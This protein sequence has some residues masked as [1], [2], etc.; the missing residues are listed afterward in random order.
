MP[1]FV[2]L[3][4]D[5]DRWVHADFRSKYFN[6]GSRANDTSVFG[7]ESIWEILYYEHTSEEDQT[8]LLRTI[9]EQGVTVLQY[10]KFQAQGLCDAIGFPVEFDGYK[11]FA[12]NQSRC[13]S[14]WFESVPGY[15]IY[16]PFSFDGSQWT[17]SLYSTKVDVSQIAKKYGG[18]GHARSAGFVCDIFP[19]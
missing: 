17:V 13:N 2:K 12:L 16:L 10:S 8:H 1:D 6:A 15:D 5:W 9:C 19:F 14:T 3:V 18:G 4:D 11:C 7:G